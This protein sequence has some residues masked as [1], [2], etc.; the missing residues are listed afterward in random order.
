[1]TR[2]SAAPPENQDQGQDPWGRRDKRPWFAPRQF[3]FGYRPQTWQ[4]YLISGGL[5]LFT[6]LIVTAAKNGNSSIGLIAVVPALAVPLIV[7]LSRR[8]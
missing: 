8:R 5:A 6:I 2:R 7:V 4:G 1:M 3:G